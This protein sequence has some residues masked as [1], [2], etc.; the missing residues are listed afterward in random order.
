MSTDDR[1]TFRGV[2]I[3]WENLDEPSRSP[4][5]YYFNAQ[6]F[7]PHII[8]GSMERA[9]DPPDDRLVFHI[10]GGQYEGQWVWTREEIEKM[11]ADGE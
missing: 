10:T 7:L 2:P 1:P 3:E 4:K 5:R 11:N 9:P 6:V 8:A